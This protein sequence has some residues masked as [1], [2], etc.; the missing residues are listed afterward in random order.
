M[1]NNQQYN[2]VTFELKHILAHF[3]NLNKQESKIFLKH[4]EGAFILRRAKKFP[5]LCYLTIAANRCICDL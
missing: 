5:F 2:C 4:N 3:E 1:H